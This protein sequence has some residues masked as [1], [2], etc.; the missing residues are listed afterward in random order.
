MIKN[1]RIPWKSIVPYLGLV[2]VLVLSTFLSNGR[3]LTA[4]NLNNILN[5]SLVVM[6]SGLGVLFVVSQG[7]LDL[8]QGGV[9]GLSPLVGYLSAIFLHP[10]LFIPVTVMTGL[11]IGLVTGVVFAN[12]R[13]PSFVLT[14]SMSFILRNVIRSLFEFVPSG[15][16][17]IPPMYFMLDELWIKLPVALVM[18]LVALYLFNYTPVGEYIRAIGSNEVVAEYSGI[19][20]KRWKRLAFVFAGASAGIAS[21]FSAVR[22]GTVTMTSGTFFEFDVLIAILLGGTPLTGGSN[23]KVSSVI[24]GALTVAVLNNGL[25]LGGVPAVYRAL[26]KGIL[27]LVVVSIS[28]ERKKVGA[29][30]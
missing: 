30:R 1:T 25:A 22:I 7:S 16:V 8:T 28:F 15:M 20:V 9:L 21:I 3:T 10:L 6:M 26:T 2:T 13:V 12:L 29:V 17:F 14:L 19:N 11:L 23:S 27:F 4:R 24:V 18:M 5:Q